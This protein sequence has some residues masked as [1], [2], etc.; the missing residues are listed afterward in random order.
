MLYS[1]SATFEAS[2]RQRLSSSCLPG[3]HS[4]FVISKDDAL[5][6]NYTSVRAVLRYFELP[7]ALIYWPTKPGR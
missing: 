3:P 5:S 1:G 2:F 6:V 7:K 4:P